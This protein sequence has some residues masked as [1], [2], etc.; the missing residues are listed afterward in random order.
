MK[1]LTYGQLSPDLQQAVKTARDCSTR[2]YP[3][4]SENHGVGAILVSGDKTF[5]GAGIKRRRFN[6]STCAER[7]A[8]DSAL[9]SGVSRIDRIVLYA[10]NDKYPFEK[11]VSPCGSCR[12]IIYE[13]MVNLGQTDIELVLANQD[14]S[15][16]IITSISELLPLVYSASTRQETSAA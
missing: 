9:I 15:R 3:K 12:Q 13:A 16:I 4:N 2:Q 10:Q 5:C 8:I 1:Q 7:H 6:S 11:V 14:L